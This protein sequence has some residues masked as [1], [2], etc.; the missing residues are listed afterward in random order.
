MSPATRN[1]TCALH[2]LPVYSFS[3]FLFEICN[4]HVPD[5]RVYNN[6]SLFAL[7]RRKHLLHG[8]RI[9]T[10]RGPSSER[11]AAH[12]QAPGVVRD[13]ASRLAQDRQRL[14]RPPDDD[15][16]R[17]RRIARAG[18]DCRKGPFAAQ[19]Q[20]TPS[21]ESLL[22]FV[23]VRPDGSPPLCRRTTPPPT[24]SRQGNRPA[25]LFFKYCVTPNRLTV[26]VLLLSS[27]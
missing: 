13:V 7:A 26:V 15:N 3:F 22:P 10:E 2:C 14:R 4:A 24:H 27:N 5:M 19:P 23:P 16:V 8:G 12:T 1:S 6:F 25:L 20:R 21:A 17:R 11:P 18:D 9:A